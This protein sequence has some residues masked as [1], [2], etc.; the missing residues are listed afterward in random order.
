MGEA[1][2]RRL[3][4]QTQALEAMTVD[5]PRRSNSRAVG[6]RC[7]C[8]TECTADFLC[9]V[10][11]H[12]RRL[13]VLGQELLLELLQSQCAQQARC[14]G[15]MAVGRTGRSQP[16]RPNYRL[17]RRCRKSADSGNAK[18]HQRRRA[19][20]LVVAHERLA[21][22]SLAC[23]PTP[24]Q[25]A[26]RIEHPLDPRIDTTIKP[27]YGKQSGAEVSYNPHKPGRP[28]HALHTYWVGNLRL[29]LDVVVSPAKSIALPKRDLV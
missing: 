13:R 14:A 7:Q 25:R 5:T 26:N 4:V 1:K 19:A 2:R 20:S 21:K 17:A 10:L 15:N 6:P 29:V 16:L 9:R 12:H 27:L 8:H 3:L 23:A 28:N 24:G 18:D 11:G 22:P